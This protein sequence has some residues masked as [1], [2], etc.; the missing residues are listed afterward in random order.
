MTEPL[1]C[2]LCNGPRRPPTKR[3]KVV[4]LCQKCSA[5]I[6][7]ASRTRKTPARTQE[8]QKVK[9]RNWE[10]C[11]DTRAAKAKRQTNESFWTKPG[12]DF[13]AAARR[14]AGNG[15]TE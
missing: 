2:R 6:A 12:A 11:S 9:R 7:T 10:Y 5:S 1:L 14:M 8:L 13:D 3:T 4:G 15:W